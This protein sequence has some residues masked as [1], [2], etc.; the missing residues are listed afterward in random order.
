M[1]Q[2][3]AE[4]ETE[5]NMYPLYIV[6]FF[7]SLFA[8]YSAIQI[9]KEQIFTMQAAADISA[10]NFM[11]YRVSVQKY[12]QSNPSA[13]GTIPDSALSG[14]WLPGYIRDPNWSNLVSGGSL[15][16]YSTN[17][18]SQSLVEQVF[19]RSN[20][21]F[22]I[23]RKN[24]LTGRLESARGLDTGVLLPASIP[25]NALVILGK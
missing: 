20:E 7:G 22:L 6:V 5:I 15:F 18:P 8:A 24:T 21:S 25:N 23:G 19:E 2:Q 17:V 11:A 13:T 10:C 14:Y 3:T 12:L 4:L 9:P 1:I 16:V